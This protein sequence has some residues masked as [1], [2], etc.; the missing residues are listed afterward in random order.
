M[1]AC[2][3]FIWLSELGHTVAYLVEALSYK[4]E[5]LGFD[6]YKVNGFFS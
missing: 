1:L 3:I 5:G 2:F 6:P 4:L